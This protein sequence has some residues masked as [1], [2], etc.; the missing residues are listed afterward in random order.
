VIIRCHAFFG[1]FLLATTMVANL[2][3]SN[4]MYKYLYFCSIK[5]TAVTS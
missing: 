2:F 1:C 4:S 3:L 5:A